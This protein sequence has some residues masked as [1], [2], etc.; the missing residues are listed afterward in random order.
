MSLCR[1]VSVKVRRNNNTLVDSN[2][3][4][5][6]FHTRGNHQAN[7]T[8]KRNEKLEKVV[9]MSAIFWVFLSFCCFLFTGFLFALFLLNPPPSHKR[10][11][12]LPPPPPPGTHHPCTTRNTH[13]VGN[14]LH[15]SLVIRTLLA[16]TS[17][18]ALPFPF[19]GHICQMIAKWREALSYRNSDLQV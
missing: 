16:D 14:P 7:V 6:K 13:R 19:F 15:T 18:T 12:P 10:T 8:K 2:V 17:F 9:S 11:P 4:D 5:S 1:R 3:R